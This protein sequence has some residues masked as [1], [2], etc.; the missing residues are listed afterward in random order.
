[1]DHEVGRLAL[2]LF[3]LQGRVAV[4]EEEI[5]KSRSAPAEEPSS[6]RQLPFPSL[7]V[8][9]NHERGWPMPGEYNPGN[10]ARGE[11]MVALMIM[12][13]FFGLDDRLTGL[14]P[15]ECLEF[16]KKICG[17]LRLSEQSQAECSDQIHRRLAS[18]YPSGLQ[19]P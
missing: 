1:M 13:R 17:G 2:Q 19:F 11:V 8:S 12:D 5:R 18:V 9:A 14:D 16:S 4:L 7:C 6:P 3:A 15:K 10:H